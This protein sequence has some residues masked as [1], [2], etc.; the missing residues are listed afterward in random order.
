MKQ[1][2]YYLILLELLIVLILTTAWEFWLEDFTFGVINVNHAQEGL[3]ERLEY[4]IT[5]SVFV[6]IALI[7]P[8]GIIIR[9]FSRLEK[10]TQRLQGALDNIKTL[11]GLLPMCANCKNIRDDNGYWQQVEVYIRQHSKAKCSH[12]ICPECAHQLYPDL[13]NE[14]NT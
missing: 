6:C 5:S 13:F 10:A 14:A 1:R 2:I 3:A 7:M 9:D 11:E 8:I 12:S 4:M